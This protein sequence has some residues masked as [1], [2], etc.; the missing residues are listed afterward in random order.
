MGNP[1]INKSKENAIP[2]RLPAKQTTILF[3]CTG[4]IFRSMSAQY[5]FEKYTKE[6]NI[7]NYKASSAGINPIYP[8]PHP[9]TIATLQ[10]LGITLQHTPKKLQEQDIAQAS[11]IIAMG[12]NHQAYIKA[13]Y[14]IEVPLFLE[15]A[16]GQKE[17]VRDVDE[18]I[19]HWRNNP[20]ATDEH[21]QK[22]IYLINDAM[23]QLISRIPL[24]LPKA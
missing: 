17:S 18:T 7:S 19:P 14:G 22:T 15:V 3:V 8:G 5:L 21:I 2:Q 6:H 13:V 24:F 4:N 20:Q 11:L 12:F 9:T 23:P 1:K 16:Y 10:A